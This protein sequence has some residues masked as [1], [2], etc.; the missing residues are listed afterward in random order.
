MGR[1]TTTQSIKPYQVVSF[2]AILDG[3]LTDGGLLVELV[4]G[5][6]VRRQSDGHVLRLGFVH[7]LLHDLR[8]FLVEQRLADL[9]THH[10]RRLRGDLIETVKTQRRKEHVNYSKFLKLCGRLS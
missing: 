3:S 8:A 4:S 7:Q 2:D 10:R 6:E 9:D 1:K 5:D